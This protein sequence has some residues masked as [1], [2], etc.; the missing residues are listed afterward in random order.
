MDSL[1]LIYYAALEL[2]EQSNIDPEQ[3]LRLL[4]FLSVPKQG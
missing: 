2:V 4:R 3:L 1:Q